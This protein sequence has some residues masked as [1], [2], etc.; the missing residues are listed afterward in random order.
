MTT[1]SVVLIHGGALGDFVLT[2]HLL[3]GLIDQGF[4]DC[5]IICRRGYHTLLADA[6]RTIGID[7]ETD[8]AQRLFGAEA[9]NVLNEI[10][11]T[12]PRPLCIIDCLGTQL[13]PHLHDCPLAKIY[14]PL[15]TAPQA[16]NESHILVQWA[17]QLALVG[18]PCTPRPPL[19]L[20]NARRSQQANGPK[21][22]GIV[23]H[24][25]AG[26]R[27]KC[28]PLDRWIELARFGEKNGLKITWAL[29]PVEL[30][31]WTGADLDRLAS[32]GSICRC[33][34][35]GQLV[36]LLRYVQ[37]FVGNDSGPSHLAA[38][39]GC[40]SV[41]IFQSTNPNIWS[42]VDAS[43]VRPEQDK[44]PPSV[45]AVFQKVTKLMS[46]T[47]KDMGTMEQRA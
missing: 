47:E 23:L 18:I 40:P 36:D 10:T 42:P 44:R 15:D 39:L 7:L 4:E 37:F 26:G 32:I 20:K 6:P 45:E 11:R 38:A 34:Q 31:T 28:W 25:G 22:R 41:V 35:L 5:L 30:D 16:G 43:L 33:I 29:G 17:A 1:G 13:P 21:D 14:V 27:N 9:G 8:P 3:Q 24:P 2:M 46:V 12:L 19:W